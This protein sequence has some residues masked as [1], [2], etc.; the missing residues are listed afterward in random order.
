M[1][2]FAAYRSQSIARFGSTSIWRTLLGSLII[3]VLLI[4]GQSLALVSYMIVTPG[5]NTLAEVLSAPVAIL[6]LLF[7]FA[8]AHLAV[9]V[10]ALLL[11]RR[12]YFAFWGASP[13]I[14][15]RGVVAGILA[16][17]IALGS[18]TGLSWPY[19]PPVQQ[20]P[21]GV[22]AVYV[23]PALCALLIQTS[24]EEL[25]FRGYLQPLLATRFRSPLIWFALPAC[26]FGA[27]HWQPGTFGENAWL[28]VLAA[29]LIGLITAD[30]TVRTGNIS[31]AVGLHF[32]NNAIG[33]LL[34]ATPGPLSGLGLFLNTIPPS[35]IAATR[36]GLIANI[37]IF[38]L[39]YALW[40]LWLRRRTRLLSPHEPT[41]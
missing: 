15:T 12:G 41:I 35:D 37:A 28:V 32:A 21:L 23:A 11:H 17:A 10:C 34:V 18:L 31:A 4:V 29:T 20:L 14:R 22:W 36:I 9:L 39:A 13:A 8:S 40:L 16:V 7:S 26:L 3:A 19:A 33:L 27:V 38:A 24:A 6:T 1:Q 5:P 30:V 25:V 2:S